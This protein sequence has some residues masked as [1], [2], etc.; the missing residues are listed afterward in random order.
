MLE[1][2]SILENTT[3]NYINTTLK[4]LFPVDWANFIKPE[5]D[6]QFKEDLETLIKKSMNGE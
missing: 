2:D 4:D 1:K 6:K 5:N 3:K